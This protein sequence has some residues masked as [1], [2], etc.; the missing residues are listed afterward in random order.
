MEDFLKCFK[1]YEE[2]H[3]GAFCRCEMRNIR[4]AKEQRARGVSSWQIRKKE[5]T[6]HEAKSE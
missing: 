2:D 1:C 5:R 4:I 6:S 3:E